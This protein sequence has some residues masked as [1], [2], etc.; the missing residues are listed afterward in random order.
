MREIGYS[1]VAAYISESVF[2]ETNHNGREVVMKGVTK[3]SRST[4]A[5]RQI[6][7]MIQQ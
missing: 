5:A 7:I 4:E 3:F 1:V 2:T 6:K